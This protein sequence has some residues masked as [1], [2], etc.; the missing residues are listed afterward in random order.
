MGPACRGRTQCRT[1]QHLTRN[2]QQ[3]RQALPLLLLLPA[4][5]LP[6]LVRQLQEQ[7]QLTGLIKVPV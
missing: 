3:H 4:L 5:L 6:L 1:A 7:Q 2:L